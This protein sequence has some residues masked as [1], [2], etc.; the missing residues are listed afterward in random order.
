VPVLVRRKAGTRLVHMGCWM[1]GGAVDEPLAQAGLTSLMA[2]TSLKGTVTRTAAQIA[3]DGERLGGSVSTSVSK[4]LVGWSISVPADDAQAAAHLLADVVQHPVFPDDAVQKER[5][6]MLSE[7]RARKDDMLRYPL[8]VARQALF[9]SHTYGIDALGTT[10]S[11]SSLGVDAVRAWHASAVL[12]GD[13]VLAIVGDAEPAVLAAQVAGAFVALR[14]SPRNSVTVHSNPTAPIEIVELR[15]KQQSAVA[16]LFRGPG[17]RD[18]GRHGAAMMTGIASG[19]GGRFFESLRSRQSLAYS[20]FVSLSTL[21]DAGMISAYIACAPEREMEARAGLLAEFA[22]MRDAPVSSQELERARTYAIGM[23]A[24]RQESASA[25]LGDM[26]DAWCAGEGL[27]ELDDEVPQLRAVTAS[28]VQNAVRTWCD[29]ERRVE[30]V[31]RGVSK[32]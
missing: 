13:S 27:Q 4:E 21:S 18:H 22:A 31:V 6:Q 19:L 23:H 12:A 8:A 14:P 10:D 5:E 1:Q 24:L 15:A 28:D 26:V 29:P 16:L 20:V 25:Q 30:A 17:R 7:L 2:R 11:V 9:G 32:S 3:E